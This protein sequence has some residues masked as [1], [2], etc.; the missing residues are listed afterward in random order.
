[1]AFSDIVGHDHVKEFLRRAQRNGRFPPALLLIG[2]SGVGKKRLAIE[3]CRILLCARGTDEACG[4][5]SACTR[6]AR[7]LHPD[8]FV[9]EPATPASIK[10][11]QVRDV[12]REI[13]S[14]P[15]EARA[16]GFVVDEAHLMTESAANSLL[17]SLEEPP[18]TSRIVL[19]TSAPHAL[20]ATIRSR[21]Q[22]L[23]ARAL[24]AA[25]VEA[26]LRGRGVDT[27][28]A[29]LRANLGGGSIGQA[30]ALDSDEYKSI[31]EDAVRALESSSGREV[32][33]SMDMAQALAD[34]EQ[35]ILALTVLRSLLR[36]VQALASGASDETL[37]NID[38]A[39]RLRPLSSGRLSTLAASMAEA[40]GQTR[41]ALRG[42]AYKPLA[43]DNLLDVIRT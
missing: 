20:P 13:Q 40:A 7:G 25:V 11:E 1:M 17:K 16:R 29:R 35:P 23:R 6:S 26:F 15:F 8:L 12:I 21:C 5:C 3:A 22:V 27:A 10:I 37:M 34:S 28:D 4:A 19:V 2:P 24:P 31:R 18:A 33:A 30:L 32:L 41:E 38:M 39:S 36:D 42:N 9:V 14:R 43:F